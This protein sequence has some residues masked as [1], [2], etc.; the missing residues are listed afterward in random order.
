[1]N[2]VSLVGRLAKEPE[3]KVISSGT[4]IANFTVAVDRRVKA[5]EE[6]Q[7][8]FINCVAFSKTAEYIGNYLAKGR[9]VSV[10]GRIQTRSWTAQDGGK[11]YATEIMCDSVQGLDRPKDG[12]T[13]KPQSQPEASYENDM[14]DPFAFD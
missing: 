2:C 13:A 12:Q 14:E 5:G 9:L 6:K 1:M 11:R 3:I 7:A 4:T 8:D 10:Q